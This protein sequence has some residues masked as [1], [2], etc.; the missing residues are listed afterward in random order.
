M[1][2]P[3]VTAPASPSVQTIS[4]IGYFFCHT[5]H[6]THQPI[7]RIFMLFQTG[8][9]NLSKNIISFLTF[10]VCYLVLFHLFPFFNLFHSFAFT[11]S[12][13]TRTCSGPIDCPASC[14]KPLHF[15]HSVGAYRCLCKLHMP[16]IFSV[17]LIYPL[18]TEFPLHTSAKRGFFF[19]LILL[20]FFG[21]NAVVLLK[22]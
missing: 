20:G 2:F 11:C 14:R 15:T 19:K 5:P 17:S 21:L 12:V 10:F 9:Q 3:S 8:F 7:L 16:Q 22:P 1:S 13:K 6:S 18:L 4:L